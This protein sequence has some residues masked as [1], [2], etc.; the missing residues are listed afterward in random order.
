MIGIWLLAAA[1]VA[2]GA[3]LWLYAAPVFAAIQAKVRAGETEIVGDVDEANANAWALAASPAAGRR[4]IRIVAATCVV[5]GATVA[6]LGAT[7]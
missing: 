4:R 6:W 7:A 2:L 3:W 1:L 5:A